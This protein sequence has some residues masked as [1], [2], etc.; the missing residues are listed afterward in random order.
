MRKDQQT[1]G[2]LPGGTG[3]RL[4]SC[5][6]EG[7]LFSPAGLGWTPPFP[8]MVSKIN[9]LLKYRLGI[10]VRS[11]VL[12]SCGLCL[13]CRYFTRR[14]AGLPQCR[15]P[16]PC[17]SAC[18]LAPSKGCNSQAKVLNY[19]WTPLPPGQVEQRT[20]ASECLLSLTG[21]SSCVIAISVNLVTVFSLGSI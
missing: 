3:L 4:C 8:D 19:F 11:G 9:S 13:N 7:S 14:A 2:C 21:L 16:Q 20:K 17:S 1:R 18:V 10:P 6:P 12:A 5:L 15:S